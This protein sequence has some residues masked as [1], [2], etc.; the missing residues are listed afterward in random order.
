MS[1]VKITPLRVVILAFA[2]LVG[3]SAWIQ[4][5]NRSSEPDYPANATNAEKT[6]MLLDHRLQLAD[7]Q[8]TRIIITDTG[9]S[10]TYQPKRS[11]DGDVWV[12]NVFTIARKAL[13]A[14]Q[15]ASPDFDKKLIINGSSHLRV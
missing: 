7:P 5:R 1:G 4:E 6:R 3:A 2:V 9:I 13:T 8:I 10:I 11:L 15:G 14:I 12:K